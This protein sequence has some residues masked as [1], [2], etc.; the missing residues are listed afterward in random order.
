MTLIYISLEHF[1]SFYT[2][3]IKGR[4]KKDKNHKVC[5]IRDILKSNQ[6][7]A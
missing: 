3:Q 4:I 7:G 6:N 5:V 1:K 2:F